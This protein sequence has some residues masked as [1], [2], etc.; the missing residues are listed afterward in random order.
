MK[1]NKEFKEIPREQWIQQF[2]RS[3]V[4]S[5]LFEYKD[6]ICQEINIKLI[7]ADKRQGKV[8]DNFG[9]IKQTSM[10]VIIDFMRKH[11]NSQFNESYDNQLHDEESFNDNPENLAHQHK[12]LEIINT[13]I[14]TFPQRCQN[15]LLLYLR[16]MKINEIVELTGNSKAIVRNDIY[17]SKE[18]LLNT[19]NNQ[20]IQYE[21]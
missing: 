15:S 5:F 2:V 21:I 7:K 10:S 13:I 12:L 3:R 17:R 16:G 4:P 8:I 1:Q 9:Y 14:L 11:R 6:D 19:L 18:K 20:G